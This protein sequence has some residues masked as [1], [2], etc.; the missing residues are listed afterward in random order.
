VLAHSFWESYFGED[1]RVLGSTIQLDG[2]PHTVIGVMPEDFDFSPANVDAYRP[3]DWSERREDREPS[4]IVL[5]RLRPG[6]SREGADA[7]LSSI[8]AELA[9]EYPEANEGYSARAQ[10]LRDWFPGSTDQ[11]LM[12]I[13][14]TV[15]GF[16]LLIA[17][18][19]IANLMLARAEERQREVAVRTAMGAGRWR[20]LRQLLTESVLLA[21]VGGALGTLLSVYSIHWVAGFMPAMMPRSFM[22]ELDGAVLVFTLAISVLAGMVFGIVP[23]VHSFGDDIRD[24]L[25]ENSR[26]GTATRKRNR[27]RSAFVVAELA[28]ALAL[29]VGSGVLMKTFDELIMQNPGFEVEGLLTA[30]VTASKNAYPEERDVLR[31]CENIQRRLEEIPAVE[32]I[33]VMVD[34]PRSR[35]RTRG[36]FTI[37][38]RPQPRHN[39]EPRT[40]WQ[41]V[42]PGYFEALGVPI[43]AGRALS[44]TDREDTMAVAVANE[45]FVETFF[46]GEDPI[47]KQ[48]TLDGASRRIVGVARNVFQTRMPEEGGE[49]PPL[50]YVPFAQHPSR[51]MSFAMRVAKEPAG[52]APE[53][54]KAVWNVDPELPVS[55]V[56]TLNQ[57]IESE[58]A[59][60]RV[61]SIVLATFGSV[62]L[63][64]SA[65]GIYGVM[66][67]SVAQRTREI[68]IR[69]ALGALQK[70]VVKLVTRQ[71]M[72][73]AA[74]GLLLGAP[75]AYALT[76]M[77]SSALS[78]ISLVDTRLV[79]VVV[80]ALLTVAFVATYLPARR[81]ARI[82]PVR[83]LQVE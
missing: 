13:L 1:D 7:E 32:S 37:D 15:A 66:A 53:V 61:I 17:C 27:L 72:W 25:G 69:M 40:D 83:A 58:L 68:G 16:V 11:M 42:N 12:R 21:L 4:L 46:P 59:G 24:S 39:E 48:I 35:S 43:L 8:A 50:V 51:S 5:G 2:E 18:A 57:H 47:G 45:I 31:L 10:G 20:I 78:E 63:L 74:L 77:I 44:S 38:G 52:L 33:A 54:R 76:R 49:L 14:M 19:N 36:E 65:I 41:S 64:L 81:A 26:G 6:A 56:Q 80:V 9:R 67:H 55:S 28:A 75:M 70:D 62:A 23:A 22:P 71:G 82:A 60:P 79:S 34:L 73:L 29:L 30:Q 3:T